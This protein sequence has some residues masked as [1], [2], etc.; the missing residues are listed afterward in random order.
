MIISGIQ[1]GRTRWLAAHL[2]NAADNEAVEVAEVTGTVATDIDGALA[3][4]DAY[5]AGTRATEGVYA[6]FINP[7]VPLSRAQYMR[8]IALIEQRLSEIWRHR[9][10]RILAVGVIVFAVV[11]LLWGGSRLVY[12]TWRLDQRS[13]A[14]GLRLG[15]VY[16]ALPISG[17][18]MLFYSLAQLFGDPAEVQRG[19]TQEAT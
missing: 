1:T 18:L 3:E 14:M 16:L 5:A 8:A 11:V 4:F 12:I 19:A 9:L 6:A 7:P 15:V 17:L 13:A 2:Q 10:A